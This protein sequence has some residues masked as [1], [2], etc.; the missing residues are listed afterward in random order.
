MG[1]QSGSLAQIY[2]PP[3]NS[4]H[5]YTMHPPE[6]TNPGP[7]SNYNDM[8]Y[9]PSSPMLPI[10]GEVGINSEEEIHQTE[11]AQSQPFGTR[12][13][14]H[15]YD[16]QV[17]PL[18]QVGSEQHIQDPGPDHPSLA[19]QANRW[20]TSGAGLV[21]LH[22]QHKQK[23]RP[24]VEHPKQPRSKHSALN[25]LAI[26]SAEFACKF[27]LTLLFQQPS[28]VSDLEVI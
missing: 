24:H 2:E 9:Y 18:Q 6:Q 17:Y 4:A 28:R 27:Y 26:F 19:G 1:V 16:D 20:L 8:I 14:D 21:F 10:T 22:T 7:Q 25:K 15:Y 12:T 3:Y 23:S 11:I 13:E 5:T